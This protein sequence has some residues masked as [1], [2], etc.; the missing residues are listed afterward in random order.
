MEEK[1][2]EYLKENLSDIRFN[3]CLRVM[4]KAEELAL[5]YGENVEEARLAG[6]SHDIAKEIPLPKAKE[7]VK[8]N[9]VAIDEIEE[10]A[11]KLIHGPLGAF[12]VKQKFGLNERIQKAIE[13]HTKTNKDMDLLAKIVFVADKVE[14]GRV[15]KKYD[16]EHERELAKSDINNAMI[17]IMKATMINRLEKN[18]IIHPNFMETMNRLIIEQKTKNISN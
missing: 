9:N 2:I 6:L 10:Y 15:T 4:K 8:E 13:Y 11:P 7:M 18:A 17:E 14:D 1:I 16:I 12:L 3:H 5:I